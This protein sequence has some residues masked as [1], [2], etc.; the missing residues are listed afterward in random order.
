MAT[1][2]AGLGQRLALL[3]GEDLRQILL[4]LGDERR[5][6]A[7][8]HGAL[9]GGL[10]APRRVG[11][12]RRLDRLAGLVGAGIRHLGDQRAGRRV[13]DVDAAGAGLRPCAADQAGI[14]QQGA[15][16]QGGGLELRHPT[17]P[18]AAAACRS[19]TCRAGA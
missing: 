3:G 5:E 17:V 4:M 11:L 16:L 19:G 2:A 10:G 1:L 14:D 9:V 7:Q 15:V 8:Q 13:G 6:L 18:S 12:V